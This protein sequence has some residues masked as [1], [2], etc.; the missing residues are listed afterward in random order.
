MTTKKK[1]NTNRVCVDYRK[2]NKL[3]ALLKVCLQWKV[4]LAYPASLHALY[5]NDQRQIRR[6]PV[7]YLQAWQKI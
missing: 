6:Q 5:A 4:H 2:L 1:D 7:G 3:T